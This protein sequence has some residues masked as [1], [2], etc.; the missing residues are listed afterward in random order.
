VSQRSPAPTFG[1]VICGRHVDCS[2]GQ[3]V[4]RTVRCANGPGGATIGCA[5]FGR[6]SC[7]GHEQWL[8]GDASDCPV[9]HSTEGRNCLPRLSPTA[10]SCL[11]AI[12]GAPRRM[13]EITKLSR[14]ILR[15]LDSDST[16]LILC[17]SDLSPI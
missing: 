7:T 17:V 16:H 10:P 12:K 15:L 14:N 2:N 8:S 1:R 4:H 3:L 5:G 13:E 6:R 9:H 11:G